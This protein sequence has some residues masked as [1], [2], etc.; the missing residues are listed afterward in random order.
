MATADKKFRVSVSFRCAV[1]ANNELEAVS[2]IA[3]A[4]RLLTWVDNI[5]RLA[6]HTNGEI[7]PPEVPRQVERSSEEAEEPAASEAV[8]EGRKETYF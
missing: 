6:A 5:H 7:R 4:L 2:N 8:E 3:I 1:E